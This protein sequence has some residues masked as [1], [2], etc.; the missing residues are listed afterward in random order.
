MQVKCRY[1]AIENVTIND[2]KPDSFSIDAV[3]ASRLKRLRSNK[4]REIVEVGSDPSHLAL[5]VLILAKEIAS[6][7]RY[8]D[9]MMSDE[10]EEE[11]ERDEF[12]QTPL[13]QVICMG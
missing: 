12:G 2:N 6:R 7:C 8:A 10:D 4:R 5:D 13:H 1:E 3:G 9:R 11:E